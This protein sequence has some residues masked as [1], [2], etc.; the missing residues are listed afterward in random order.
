MAIL[1]NEVF[2]S[3]Q[4]EGSLV[5]TPSAFVRLQGCPCGCPWCDTGY[6]LDVDSEHRLEDNSAA[7]ME[8]EGPTP[9][10]SRV[11]EAWLVDEI[12]RRSRAG[13]HVVITGGEPCRQDLVPLT[14]ALIAR[15]FSVQV[16]TSGT[17]RI[18]CAPGTWI[19]ISPKSL[20]VLEENW[21]RADEIKLPVESDEDV[22]RWLERLET[23]P[24]GK[25]W[26]QPVSQGN[27]ATRLC[28]AWC[29]RRGW[30]LSVQVHK[31]IGLR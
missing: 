3:L 24:P 8:K 12:A 23:L 6:A 10:F 27:E 14:S 9:A 17:Q 29:M 15:G 20:P 16:E 19:T 11:D 7:I 18:A 13:L 2:W 31:Y 22:L 21:A 30:R 5:G 28:V 1:V 26:L 4:G 25:V